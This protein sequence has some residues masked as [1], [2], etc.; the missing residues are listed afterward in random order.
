MNLFCKCHFTNMHQ[1]FWLPAFLKPAHL[2]PL[3]WKTTDSFPVLMQ[4]LMFSSTP[5][6]TILYISRRV[7]G[8]TACSWAETAE[9]VSRS[10]RRT[11]QNP[12]VGFTYGGGVLLL[13]VQ[14]GAT[15]LL[16]VAVLLQRVEHLIGQ[17]QVHPQ[18]VTDV[19]LW[20]ELWGGGRTVNHLYEA[21]SLETQL[22]LLTK[23]L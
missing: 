19:D 10:T 20:S 15:P 17:L 9:L 12:A 5:A 18:T 11:A 22:D 1:R 7:R 3:A 14:P 23:E 21:G 16:A 8:S 2:P 4:P 13:L 6:F